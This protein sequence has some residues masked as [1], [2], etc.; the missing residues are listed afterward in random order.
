MYGVPNKKVPLSSID[1][2]SRRPM[3]ATPASIQAPM[4]Y[5]NHVFPSATNRRTVTNVE[6]G[7]SVEIK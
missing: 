4:H 1:N 7:Q 6:F 3:T 5:S 2:L